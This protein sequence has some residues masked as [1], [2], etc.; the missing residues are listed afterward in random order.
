MLKTEAERELCRFAEGASK[1]L[2]PIGS[3]MSVACQARRA[4]MTSSD[5]LS[6]VAALRAQMQM[7]GVRRDFVAKA[8]KTCRVLRDGAEMLRLLTESGERFAL[9]ILAHEVAGYDGASKWLFYLAA[10]RDSGKP[11][12]VH[13]VL[14]D[15][16]AK[17][18][19]LRDAVV[20]K[21]G[22]TFF[23][24]VFSGNTHWTATAL[25]ETAGSASGASVWPEVVKRIGGAA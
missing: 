1:G 3:A 10:V 17:A 6:V 7:D 23:G 20:K 9:E 21:W 19:A 13:N 14:F 12:F 24:D 2:S 8:D 22:A 18:E 5:M 11:A 16:V 25:N 4:G 15:D